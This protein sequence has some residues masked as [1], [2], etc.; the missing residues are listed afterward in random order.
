MIPHEGTGLRE[1][2][3]FYFISPMTLPS[4]TAP[5]N[6]SS[7]MQKIGKGSPRSSPLEIPMQLQTELAR[8]EL[9][10][11]SSIP[12]FVPEDA[13]TK[14]DTKDPRSALKLN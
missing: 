7:Q 12:E 11:T 1:N 3:T 8:E 9:S 2:Y 13:E 10:P 6:L 14:I 4:L 5:V